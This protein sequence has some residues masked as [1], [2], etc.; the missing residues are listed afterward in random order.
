MADAHPLEK[1]YAR[2]YPGEVATFLAAQGDEAIARVLDR[3]P[4][5]LAGAVAAK[6]P[7]GHARR[8]LAARDDASIV[9]WLNAAGADNAMALLLNL[10]AA[11]RTSV[12]AALP[13]RR[14][15]RT[16]RRLL[17]YPD[18]TVGSLVDP[19]AMRLD[20]AMPLARAVGILRTDKP[21]SEQSIWLV[22]GEGAYLGRLDLSRVLVV[23][24]AKVKIGE[25]LVPVRPLRAEVSL[26]N[27]RDFSE[28]DKFLEL[29]VIDHL[30]HMLGTLSRSRL[31]AALAAT[32]PADS[33]LIPGMGEL[34]QQY[35]R[36][37]GICLGD[38]LGQRGR[39]R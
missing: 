11:R 23:E 26:V 35:F 10:A 6:L 33:G 14:M 30:D 13:D 29:P 7:Q 31:L 24:S 17:N 34:A 32:R 27:A 25:L 1:A 38:L 16:L 21:G 9:N 19:A 18:T 39:D 22:D 8:A 20:A 2:E 28:W 3:L 15:R 4:S 5:D 36:V 37:L 12:L